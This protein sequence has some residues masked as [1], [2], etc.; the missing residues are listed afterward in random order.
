MDPK[1]EI[2]LVQNVLEFGNATV[3]MFNGTRSVASGIVNF[4]EL[5]NPMS[6]RFVHRGQLLDA[7]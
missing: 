2:S 3:A 6:V 4:V 1:V 7:K 5:M